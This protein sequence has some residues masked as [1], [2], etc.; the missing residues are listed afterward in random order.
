MGA[1]GVSAGNG[2]D[3]AG[4]VEKVAAVAANSVVEITTESI[5]TGDFFMQQIK[6]GAGSGVVIT[7]DGY[8]ATNNHVIDG[9]NKITVTMKDGKQ[10]PAT[11]VGT[12]KKTDLAVIKIKASGL[13]PAVF[14]KS[15][16]LKVGEPAI[17]IGNPLGQLGGTVTN[18]IISA[19]DR[20]ITIDGEEMCI[21]DRIY[22][23]IP[24]GYY[25]H[26]RLA[27]KA[28]RHADYSG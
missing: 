15:S 19:L 26:A 9:A 28:C 23:G 18:G 14:G 1:S 4:T 27:Q 11:L 5:E 12:D 16:E 6:S 2:D 10:Y 8:I 22:R 24:G 25:D 20:Q 3:T 7:A 13:Q 21:R 17:A